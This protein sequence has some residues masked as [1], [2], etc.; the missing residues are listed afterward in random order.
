MTTMQ[1][2]QA[3]LDA[4]IRLLRD[5]GIQEVRRCD[6]GQLYNQLAGTDEVLRERQDGR[7]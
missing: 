1:A 4:A 6:P 7:R 3:A 5:V 2:A